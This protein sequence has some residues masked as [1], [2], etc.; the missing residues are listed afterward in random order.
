MKKY[1]WKEG[2][3]NISC[4][5]YYNTKD[6]L[7]V[8]QVHNIS[9]TNIWVSKIYKTPTNE[10]YLGQYISLEYAKN[11]IERHFDIQSRTLLESDF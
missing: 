4:Y 3:N 8:G 7:I 2:G 11:A 10:H 5:Y 9:H 6:G 1:D